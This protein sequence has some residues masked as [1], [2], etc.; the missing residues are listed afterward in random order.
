MKW[1]SEITASQLAG[2]FVLPRNPKQKCIFIAGGIGVT[3]F[4]SMFKYLLDTRQHRPVVL[5]YSVKTADEIV[6][7]DVFDRAQKELGVKVFY[8]L[9]QT[10]SLPP[11]WTGKTGRITAKMIKAEVP[12]FHRCIFYLS[13]PD[14]MVESFKD[15]LRELNV[16]RSQIKTDYFAGFG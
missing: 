8:T 6:Y 16:R 3:P 4:R 14:A 1:G 12:D 13:G 15:D 7:K 9:T 11:G 5:F 10:E 2:D